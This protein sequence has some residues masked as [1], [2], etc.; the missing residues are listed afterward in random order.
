MAQRISFAET[1]RVG[2]NGD[3]WVTVASV[4][5]YEEAANAADFLADARFPVGRAA[6]AARELTL[7]DQLAGRP[8][9]GRTGLN[10]AMAGG[11]VGAVV[12]LLSETF[13]DGAYVGGGVLGLMIGAITGLV[14][15]LIVRGVVGRGRPV[16]AAS[17][18]HAER[19]EVLVDARLAEEA[20]NLLTE[21]VLAR[22]SRRT[23]RG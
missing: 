14:V 16:A 2:A 12:G 1:P 10:G 23:T 11:F 19:Y 17:A 5:S 22:P 3:E 8:S 18:V 9:T 4:E 13:G 7:I 21:W 6:I 15:A 20:R